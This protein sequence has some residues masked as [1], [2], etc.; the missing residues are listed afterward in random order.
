MSVAVVGFPRRR[1]RK[2]RPRPRGWQV[3]RHIVF[4]ELS[5]GFRET[6]TGPYFSPVGA[7]KDCEEVVGGVLGQPVNSITSLAFVVAGMIVWARGGGRVVAVSLAAT[8]VGSWLFHGPM[9]GYAQLAHD[10]TLWWL[11]AVVVVI[12]ARTATGRSR[13][14]PWLGPAILLGSVAVIGRLGATSWPLCDPAS[15]WQTHGLW[16]LGAAVAVTWWAIG[17]SPETVPE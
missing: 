1:G 15:P 2:S 6:F 4:R 10:V 12:L 9:P 3:E 17:R 5:F 16:H 11:V 14:R 7:L 8:G 13:Q